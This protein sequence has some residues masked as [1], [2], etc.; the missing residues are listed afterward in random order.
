[1]EYM[2]A[3]LTNVYNMLNEQS[4]ALAEAHLNDEGSRMR[5]IELGR[6]GELAEQGTAHIIQESIAMRE[7][8]HTELESAVRQIREQ[9]EQSEATA[10]QFRQSGLQLREACTQYVNDR[11]K[12]N[13]KEMESSGELSGTD[14]EQ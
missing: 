2:R 4:Q 10:G 3:S 14:Y 13:K 11:E 6:R 9:Q 12:A 8:Y 7:R 5:I 1:M